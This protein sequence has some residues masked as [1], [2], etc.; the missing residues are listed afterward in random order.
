MIFTYSNPHEKD[1]YKQVK[2]QDLTSIASSADPKRQGEYTTG[3]SEKIRKP[4]YDDNPE[5]TLFQN[6]SD[7]K[8][9]ISKIAMHLNSNVRNDLFH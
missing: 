5:Q 9:L 8:V 2:S 6:R 3:T 1:V 7:L 4:F